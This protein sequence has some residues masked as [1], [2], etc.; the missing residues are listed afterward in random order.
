MEGA[1]ESTEL[2]RHPNQTTFNRMWNVSN[3]KS[4][5]PAYMLLGFSCTFANLGA[6]LPSIAGPLIVSDPNTESVDPIRIKSEVQNYL[7]IC[8]YF[9][10]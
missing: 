5:I 10:E 1:N 8:K 6:L 9:Q 4:T 3:V 2:R 7:S